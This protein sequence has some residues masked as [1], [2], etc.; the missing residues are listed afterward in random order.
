MSLIKKSSGFTG[1]ASSFNRMSNQLEKA[2]LTVY[3]SYSEKSASRYLTVWNDDL[4]LDAEGYMIDGP[5]VKVRFSGHALPSCYSSNN[6]GY[7]MVN[8]SDTS[9]VKDAIAKIKSLLIP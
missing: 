7:I 3:A 8:I 2:G 1:L 4:G 6:D 5:R 9:Q